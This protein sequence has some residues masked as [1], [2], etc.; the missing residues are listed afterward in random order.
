MSCSSELKEIDGKACLVSSRGSET[1]S[2]KWLYWGNPS[3]QT[4]VTPVL[5]EGPQC[6]PSPLTFS[7]LCHSWQRGWR[8]QSVWRRSL[9][10]EVWG[11]DNKYLN[12]LAISHDILYLLSYIAVLDLPSIYLTPSSEFNNEDL[13]TSPSVEPPHFFHLSD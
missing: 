2:C 9:L 12:T 1:G 4:T 7:T 5:A 6:L 3:M 8:W 10:A 13:S 11:W